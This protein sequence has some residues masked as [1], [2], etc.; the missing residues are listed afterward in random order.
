MRQ[1]SITFL[2]FVILYCEVNAQV[3]QVAPIELKQGMFNNSVSD[4]ALIF[5]DRSRKLTINEILIKLDAGKLTPVSSTPF[6]GKF[7]R[8]KFNNWIY[9]QV[10]NTE[11]SVMPLLISSDLSYDS[12]YI[13]KNGA[14]ITQSL[15][16]NYAKD[17]TKLMTIPLISKVLR[18]LDAGSQYDFIIKNYDY[19]YSPT[20]TI[21]KISD[22]RVYESKYFEENTMMILFFASGVFIIF[23]VL[24]IFGFQWYFTGDKVLL[25]YCLYAGVSL[26]IMWRNLE[27]VYPHLHSTNHLLSWTDSKLFQSAAVF[28]FYVIFVAGFLEYNPPLLHKFTRVLGWFCLCV[29]SVEILFILFNV[30]LHTR[31]LLYYG[32]RILVTTGGAITLILIWKS[33]NTL[34]KYILSGC[35][36]MIIAEMTS[37]LTGGNLSSVISLLG[38]D[39]DFIIFSVALGVRSQLAVKERLKLRL[40]K[41]QLENENILSTSRIKTQ[42]AQDIHDEIGLGLTSINFLLHEQKANHPE[43]KAALDKISQLSISLIQKMHEIIWSMDSNKDTVEEFCREIRSVVYTFMKDHHLA[44]QIECDHFNENMMING[45]LR[46]NLLLCIKECLNNVVKHSMANKLDLKIVTTEKNIRISI[47]DNGQ[48]FLM[49]ENLI[50][51]SVSGNGIKIIEKRIFELGGNVIFCNDN[52]AKVEIIVPLK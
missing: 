25:W 21:P 50:S 4:H 39:I 34:S 49:S 1:V 29:V 15:I 37:W 38:V 26:V 7:V 33:T 10:K 13:F 46:R 41:L 24:V 48:G 12:L 22:A 51:T 2:F 43:N 36:V 17:S 52:G 14:L 44:G 8:G 31:W 42:I 32:F 16:S 35:V 27:N 19:A 11:P 45:V 23:T 28:Y 47:L 6:P 40:E 18:N 9:F 3:K 5:F 30:D 20:N